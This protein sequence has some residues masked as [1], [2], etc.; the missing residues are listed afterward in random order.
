M[1][2]IRRFLAGLLLVSLPFCVQAGYSSPFFYSVNNNAVTIT[3]YDGSVGA[4]V[5]PGTIGGN[6]VTSIGVGAFHNGTMQSVVVGTNVYNI[7][8]NAFFFCSSLLRVAS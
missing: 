5:I 2:I 7:G 6:P 8:Q 1:A 3:G 4:V